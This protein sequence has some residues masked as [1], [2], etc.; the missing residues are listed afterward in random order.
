MTDEANNKAGKPDKPEHRRAGQVIDRSAK[1]EN[2]KSKRNKW[3]IRVFVCKDDSGKR[4]W[5]SETF[6]G[7][8][9]QA[10]ARA[11]DLLQKVKTGEALKA[12]NSQFS[13]FIDEWLRSH[14]DLKDSSVEHY[15]QIVDLYVRPKL[16]GLMLS[17][18]VADNVQTLYEDLRVEGLGAATVA[19]VHAILR[20]VFKL[21]ML[22][23]RIR[24]NPMDGVKGPSGRKLAQER[25]R[26]RESKV[27]TPEQARAFLAGA[28]PT[29]FGVLFT[30]AFHTGCRPGELLGLRWMDYDAAAQRVHIRMG[31][32]WR[33]AN[34]PRGHWYLDELKTESSRR[35]LRLD[36]GVVKLLAAHR[37]RQLEE[38][39]K[40]GRAWNDH[41]FVFCSEI[42]NPYSQTQL[43]YNC[44]KILRA[45][46]LP[47]IFN[48]YSAR[49]SAAT[50]MIDQGINAKTAAGRLGHADVG[51]T[52]KYY[53]HSTEG[54][55]ERAVETLAK[56]IEGKP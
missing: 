18:V 23:K 24:D 17:R 15:R 33:K 13:A 9:K 38:K 43:R 36:A 35:D 47:E 26:R 55:D 25:K 50:W 32:C 3:L 28:E 12:D 22:R 49:H 30:L 45:A 27:M 29:R 2:G 7:K 11:I 31:I 21:A 53:V 56:A 39:M 54:M 16:G 10:E 41:D 37:K 34:D 44:K 6:H 52:M 40:A 4:H 1:N 42:G 8:R 14:P 5:H 20:A 19:Q 48:P 51:T 46:G